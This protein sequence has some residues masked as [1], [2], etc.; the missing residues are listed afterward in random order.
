MSKKRHL[1][2][3]KHGHAGEDVGDLKG[4]PDPL[5]DD[6]VGRQPGNALTVKDHFPRIRREQPRHHIKQGRFS[7]P[8]R[9]DDGVNLSLGYG[10]TYVWLAL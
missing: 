6:P 10:E 9:S 3:F 8:V 2:I 7:G 4:A 1:H 5:A